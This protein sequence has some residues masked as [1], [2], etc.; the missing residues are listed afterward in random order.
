MIHDIEITNPE[1]KD[2]F[3]RYEK[4]NHLLNIKN[5]GLSRF[6]REI[7]FSNSE[8]CNAERL[9]NLTLSQGS[10]QTILKKAPELIDDEVNA[11]KS[12]VSEVFSDK[13]FDIDF[14]YRLRI[15]VK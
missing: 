11:Y 14:S 13:M 9:I 12:L 6:A 7:V 1:I 10:L 3:V 5:S 2:D 15:A 8:V 4:S